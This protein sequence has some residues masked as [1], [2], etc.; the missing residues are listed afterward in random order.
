VKR[1]RIL[2]PADDL[3][4]LEGPSV[5]LAGP[6]PRTPD[7]ASWRPKALDALRA[8]GFGGTAL[9]PEPFVGDF[10][11]QVSWEKAGLEGCSVIAFWV[12]RDLATLPGFT[13]NIEFGRYVGSGRVLYGRPPGAP[14]TRYLD[15][16]YRDVGGQEPFDDLEAL[17]RAAAERAVAPAVSPAEQNKALI[18][19][20]Y[21]D[22]WDRWDF[23]LAN[24]LVAPG[25][26]FRGS[27]GMTAEGRDA[28]LDYMQTV[29][30]AFPDFHNHL[31]NLLAEGDTVVARLTYTGTHR[32]ELF[33]IPPT[34]RR[35]S[36]AGVAFFRV[37]GRHITEGLVLGD[38][39]GLIRQLTGEP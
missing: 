8:H 25:V 18:R 39:H 37:A 3:P 21:A 4:R 9:V 14:H 34:G 2:R 26:R 35:V 36:Y 32:G 22:L 24:E 5:F 11:R 31:D 27:L 10:A 1:M 15:W 23:P 38:V 19:R 17:M 33:G 7:V 29:R 28:F 20:F 6:T 16:M 12:P 13:M 30:R